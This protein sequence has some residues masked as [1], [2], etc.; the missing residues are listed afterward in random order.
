MRKLVIF[1]TEAT[2]EVIDFYFTQDSEY[3]VAAFT[4]DAAFLEGDSYRGR[5]LVAFEDIASKFPPDDY[6]MFIAVGFQKMNA[7]RALKFAAAKSMGYTLASYLSS[8]ASAWPGFS[9]AENTFVM[10]D[11]TIQPFVTI[12]H[13]TILWSGNHVGHH[14]SIGAHC[15]VSSHVV[16][17]GR[18]TVGDYSFLGENSTLRDGVTL[19]EATMVGAGC[20]VL[21]DTPPE[22]VLTTPGSEI[23]R[24]PSR[25]LRTI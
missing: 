22:T 10:E 9:A 20:L 24:V 25:K 6:E 7:V 17:S 2:A 23:R 16:I 11:N 13:D 15:F 14:S 4:V 3:E 18:V 21:T 12:G 5:P 1:G 8:K 19:G